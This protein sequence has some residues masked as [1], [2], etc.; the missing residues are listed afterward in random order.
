ML[1]SL[2][3]CLK[4]ATSSIYKLTRSK[5]MKASSFIVIMIVTAISLL[6]Q[7]N[8]SLVRSMQVRG[9]KARDLM[10]ALAAA[11]Y[12]MHSGE[13]FGDK[14]ITIK[15]HALTCK[16]SAAILPDE[17]MSDA[18]CSPGSLSSNSN[19]LKNSLALIKALAAVSNFDGAA[20]SRYMVISGISC[21]LTYDV[22][23]YSCEISQETYY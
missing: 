14:P 23:A 3:G 21:I 17:W 19:P 2:H 18:E 12:K 5:A 8:E 7:A 9:D 6:S 15:A 22:K 11:G 10:E 16:Y 1:F 13:E 4:T 20:G